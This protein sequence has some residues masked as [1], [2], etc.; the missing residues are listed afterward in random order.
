MMNLFEQLA[1]GKAK[2][3]Y[4]HYIVDC[5]TIRNSYENIQLHTLVENMSVME[6]SR[7]IVNALR[8]W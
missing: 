6:T 5:I 2:K 3:Q 8:I 7:T 4:V 1:I